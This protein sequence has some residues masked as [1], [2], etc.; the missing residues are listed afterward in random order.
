MGRNKLLPL[1]PWQATHAA[2]NKIRT[3]HINASPDQ[4]RLSIGQLTHQEK[5]VLRYLQGDLPLVPRP[6][7][8][9]AKQARCSEDFVLQ[10]A[11]RLLQEG[12]IRRLGATVQH[13]Q[14]GYVCNALLVFEVGAI[15]PNAEG[16]LPAQVEE[17]GR[18]LAAHPAVSHCYL[19][20]LVNQTG[21][22]ATK[23]A[24]KEKPE[25]PCPEAENWNCCLF[26][27]LH[28]KTETELQKFIA[29]LTKE[30]AASLAPFD[31]PGPRVLKTLRE[32][33]KTPMRYF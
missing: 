23:D 9:V 8:W 31:L 7:A 24:G 11:G 26:A 13:E 29:D 32:L 14:A 5:L 12:V 20:S 28:A 25:V 1:P 15:W 4:P 6:Y 27:M 21:Q 30:L 33:K 2:F 19:R 18:L 3:M 17:A 10:V 22:D 16:A